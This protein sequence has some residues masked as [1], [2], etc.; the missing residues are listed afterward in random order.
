LNGTKPRFAREC[1]LTCRG[2]APRE[3]SRGDDGDG[4]ENGAGN[5]SDDGNLQEMLA[6]FKQV[7]PSVYMHNERKEDAIHSNGIDPIPD[8]HETDD[9]T[10]ALI[11]LQ[12]FT[13][14]INPKK[15]LT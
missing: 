4:L 6:H 12:G 7:D 15:C 14:H 10:A 9:S 3:T 13:R 2:S 11:A 5:G 1:S 8:S